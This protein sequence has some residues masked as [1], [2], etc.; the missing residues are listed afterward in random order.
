MDLFQRSTLKINE[1]ILVPILIHFFI[2]I[3][4]HTIGNAQNSLKCLILCIKQLKL[5]LYTRTL[6]NYY[7]QY[8]VRYR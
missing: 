3:I 5:Y 7:A 6:L 4:L 8:Y 1:F 2:H